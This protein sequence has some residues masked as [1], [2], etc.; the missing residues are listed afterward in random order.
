LKFIIQTNSNK[1]IKQLHSGVI[2]LKY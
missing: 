2:N 1:I